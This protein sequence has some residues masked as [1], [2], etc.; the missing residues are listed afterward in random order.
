MMTRKHFET[1]ATSIEKLART[2]WDAAYD[3]A[4]DI[5]DACAKDNPTQPASLEELAPVK[6]GIVLRTS[7][8]NVTCHIIRCVPV[9]ACQLLN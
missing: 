8:G 9:R 4:C 5:A 6:V 2:H 1:L 7:V 3:M